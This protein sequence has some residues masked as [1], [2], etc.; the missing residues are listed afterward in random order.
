MRRTLAIA[1]LLGAAGAGAGGACR[2]TFAPEA[3]AVVTRGD[4]V[5]WVELQ[6]EVKASRS[7]T[8]RAPADAGDLRI[9]HLLPNGATVEKGA[10]VAQFDAST[11]SRTAAEKR[12]EANALQAELDKARAEAH[13]RYA[14]AA[15][16]EATA[17]FDLERAKLDY[18][19]REVLSRVE[20]EQLRLKVR[21]A[22]QKLREARA[23]VASVEAENR[24]NLAAAAQKHAKAV[25]DLDRAEGQLRSLKVIAPAAGVLS[26][27][28]NPR[29]PWT[30]RQPFRPG[31]QV[32][33]RAE[34][35]QLPDPSS[36]YILSRVDE[37]E[38]GHLA[39]D[40]R[41][42]VRSEA[43]PDREL[44]GRVRAISA[45]AKAD[46]TSWPPPRN[47]DVTIAVEDPDPRLRPGLTATLRVAAGRLTDV[48]LVPSQAVFTRGGQE[49]VYVIASGRVE[50]RPIEIDRRSSDRVVIRR[51][52]A[53]GEQ[54]SLVD[55]S[56]DVRS[57]S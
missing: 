38:R 15:T 18:S 48:V 45:L 42:A 36:L 43:L 54:I 40:Q 31:D 35:A 52:V 14:E 57:A 9:V 1:M 3:T 7:L 53:P 20:A 34:I 46:F 37:V 12:T 26:I 56:A 24:A 8:L 32:W 47:F 33:S 17:R 19:G 23:R 2:Q 44:S 39:V 25:R 55:L 41:V 51:G 30:A 27:L 49:V 28:N 13:A 10:V 5:E 4:F 16:A 6:G 29:T 21:D 11:V 22:E 50:P